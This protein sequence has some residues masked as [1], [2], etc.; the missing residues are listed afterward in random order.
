MRDAGNLFGEVLR[1]EVV[2]DSQE[3]LVANAKLTLG[4]ADIVDQISSPAGL[5]PQEASMFRSELAEAS[6]TLRSQA[7]L[8][9]QQVLASEGSDVVAA[10]A[11]QLLVSLGVSSAACE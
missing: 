5:D 9:L 1:Y 8:L 4:Y 6:R 11:C 3:A 7:S 2:A 10:E